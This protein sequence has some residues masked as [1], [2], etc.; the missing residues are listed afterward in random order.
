MDI[1]LPRGPPG[2][3]PGSR[4]RPDFTCLGADSIAFYISDIRPANTEP[5]GA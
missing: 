5:E 2:G 4:V 1:G 3:G